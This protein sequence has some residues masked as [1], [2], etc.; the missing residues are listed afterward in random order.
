VTL[1][2]GLNEAIEVTESKFADIQK[3]SL[4]VFRTLKTTVTQSREEFERVLHSE[5]TNRANNLKEIIAKYQ[6]F[7]RLVGD[8]S[9]LQIEESDRMADQIRSDGLEMVGSEAGGVGFDLGAYAEQ[10]PPLTDLETRIIEAESTLRSLTSQI[11]TAFGDLRSKHT[12]LAGAVE[13]LQNAVDLNLSRLEMRLHKL[14]SPDAM[15]GFLSRKEL[16]QRT[17]SEFQ[18]EEVGLGEVEHAL[19]AIF[20]NLGALATPAIAG[21]EIPDRVMAGSRPSARADSGN[22]VHDRVDPGTR[23]SAKSDSSGAIHDGAE[24]G[25]RPNAT[26][27]S[28]SAGHDPVQTGTRPSAQSDR[29]SATHDGVETGI[30]R[31]ATADSGTALRDGVYPGSLPSV[32]AGSWSGR[33]FERAGQSRS[34]VG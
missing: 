11:G 30:G 25:M 2:T 13:S 1:A 23:P 7:S 15:D 12:E 29:R 4:E 27:G 31:S 28:V 17:S 10:I 8:E 16:Q 5:S 20:A 19:G 14:C 33:A 24:T 3:A 9:A 32:I 22:A 18:R 21:G 34:C 26:A 6:S